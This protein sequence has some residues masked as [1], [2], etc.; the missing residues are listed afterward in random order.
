MSYTQEKKEAVKRL[1]GVQ[2]KSRQTLN[3]I[4]NSDSKEFLNPN[5]RLVKR[6]ELLN[7][8]EVYHSEQV[9]LAK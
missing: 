4:A 3:A 9:R 6:L 2:A 8:F 1:R 7:C 5:S